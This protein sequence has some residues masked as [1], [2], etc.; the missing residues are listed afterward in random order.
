[1]GN[2]L[3]STNFKLNSENHDRGN[4]RAKLKN[5]YTGKDIGRIWYVPQELSRIEYPSDHLVGYI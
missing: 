1:V 3:H 2:L 5:M 4:I